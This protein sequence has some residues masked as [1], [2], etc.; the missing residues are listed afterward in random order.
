MSAATKRASIKKFR[1]ILL[2]PIGFVE[3]KLKH[4][5]GGLSPAAKRS[6]S[7]TV[8]LESATIEAMSTVLAANPAINNEPRTTST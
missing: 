5:H 3:R 2:Q 8:K 7:N 4:A 1:T 6:T